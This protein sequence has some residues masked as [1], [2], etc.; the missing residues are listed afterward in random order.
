MRLWLT[1]DFRLQKQMLQWWWVYDWKVNIDE[2]Q[3]RMNPDDEVPDTSNSARDSQRGAPPSGENQTREGGSNRSTTLSSDDRQQLLQMG[4]SA[5][6]IR[7]A[8]DSLLRAGESLSLSNSFAH[9][10]HV[11]NRSGWNPT[12]LKSN[13]EQNMI[14]FDNAWL[15]EFVWLERRRQYVC[16]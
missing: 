12:S 2:L 10:L 3:R 11:H 15:Q 6:M 9:S 7:S 14:T 16:H 13:S 4:F 1:P 5:D 8:Q